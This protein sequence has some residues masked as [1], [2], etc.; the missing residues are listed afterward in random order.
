M[1]CGIC[2]TNGFSFEQPCQD[3]QGGRKLHAPRSNYKLD[4]IFFRYII[5]LDSLYNQFQGRLSRYVVNLFFVGARIILNLECHIEKKRTKFLGFIDSIL[6]G[7]EKY[8]IQ[9]FAKVTIKTILI[10]IIY[11][12]S[13]Q[14]HKTTL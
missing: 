14:K 5:W 2:T 3:Q 6:E 10:T 9:L 12:C 13:I 1:D 7:G 11:H 4:I 8:R